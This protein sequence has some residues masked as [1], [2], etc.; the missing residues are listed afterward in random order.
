M[1][2]RSKSRIVFQ[3]F[4]YTAFTIFTILI[5]LP[6]LNAIS[7]SLSDYKFV[8]NG[9]VRFWPKGFNLA[10]YDLIVTNKYFLYTLGNTIFLTVVNTLLTIV[11]ALAAGYALASKHMVGGKVLM[12]IY[13][14]PMYFSGGLIPFY[15]VVQ[16]LELRETYWALILPVVVNVFYII[17][18]R[19]SI[20]AV[21]AELAESAEMDGASDLVIL[22]R[23]IFPVISPMV[24]AFVIFSAVAFWNEWFNVMLFISD[25]K[26]STLQY[27]L[28][29]VLTRT[30]DSFQLFGR[31]QRVNFKANEMAAAIVT[32][33]PIVLVYPFLQRYFIHGIIVGAVKG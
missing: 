27:W 6:F 15:L 14:I 11:L 2:Y 9:E 28:R 29:G 33:I 12:N 18:F 30:F 20:A 16:N 22:S 17:I 10:S 3:I 24:A 1:H 21:P 13:L 23:V 5:L 25:M 32:I 8:N 31:D 26:M 7:I 4:N 19:N